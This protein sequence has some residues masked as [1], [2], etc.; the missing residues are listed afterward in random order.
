VPVLFAILHQSE[1]QAV[2]VAASLHG[3]FGHPDPEPRSGRK[4]GRSS[5]FARCPLDHR[6]NRQAVVLALAGKLQ[7]DRRDLAIVKLLALS[8]HR[9]RRAGADLGLQSQ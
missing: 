1:V 8:G 7:Q 4:G 6:R 2:D 5:G 3:Q 9:T